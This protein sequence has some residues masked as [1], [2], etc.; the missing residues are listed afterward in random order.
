MEIS[1]GQPYPSPALSPGQV[2]PVPNEEQTGWAPK[3]TWLS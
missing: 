1:S 2:P 3:P